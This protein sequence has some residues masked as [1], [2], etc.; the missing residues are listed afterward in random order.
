MTNIP[1]TAWAGRPYKQATAT[2]AGAPTV[3]RIRKV[4]RCS[5]AP[6]GYAT[7]SRSGAVRDDTTHPR[8]WRVVTDPPYRP[9]ERRTTMFYSY[10]LNRGGR[11]VLCPADRLGDA[12][13]SA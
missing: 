8:Q 11:G 6:L 3:G 10:V 1:T 12:G 4:K 13:A 7:S 9:V 2:A 5:R